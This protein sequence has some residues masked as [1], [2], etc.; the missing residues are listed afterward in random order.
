MTKAQKSA[1]KLKW[2]LLIYWLLC[3]IA[4]VIWL[5]GYYFDFGIGIGGTPAM[6]FFWPF[7]LFD[8][9]FLGEYG[10]AFL[11]LLYIGIFLFTQWLFLSPLWTYISEQDHIEHIPISTSIRSSPVSTNK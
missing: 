9:D 1:S 8:F 5:F 3:F 2:I 4:G 11:T 7:S 6:T 10:F